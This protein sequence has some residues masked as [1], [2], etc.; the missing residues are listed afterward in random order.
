MLEAY[1]ILIRSD[2]AFGICRDCYRITQYY[3]IGGNCREVF[4][5]FIYLDFDILCNNDTS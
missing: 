5:L 4:K 2:T 3:F 1:F